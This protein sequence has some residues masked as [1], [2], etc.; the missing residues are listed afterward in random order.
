MENEMLLLFAVWNSGTVELW[1]TQ[2]NLRVIHGGARHF[3]GPA[4]DPARVRN[5]SPTT[6]VRIYVQ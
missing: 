1:I 2:T 4:A 3:E 5:R 6:I